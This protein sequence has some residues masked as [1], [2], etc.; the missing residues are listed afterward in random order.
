MTCTKQEVYK[1]MNATNEDEA[2]KGPGYAL[3]NQTDLDP[4]K[5]QASLDRPS[6]TFPHEHMKTNID[7]REITQRIDRR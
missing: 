4:D 5:D 6:R 2:S 7:Q 1:D 3:Q